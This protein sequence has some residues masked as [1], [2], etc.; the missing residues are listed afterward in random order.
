[1]MASR[2]LLKNAARTALRRNI[3]NNFRISVPTVTKVAQFS[4][5][6]V[7][8]NSV[9]SE[10]NKTLLSELEFEK[11]DSFGLDETFLNY[12]K[13]SRFEI[14]NSDNK[15]LA[16]LVKKTEDEIIH[17]YF[18]VQRVTQASYE[19]KQLEDAEANGEDSEFLRDEFANNSFADVNVVVEKNGKAVGFDL[20]MGVSTN[21]FSVSGI[22]NFDSA[23]LALSDNA[24]DAAKR[25]LKYSG[26][27]FGNLA[28]E[29]Q[30]GIS[31]YL[32]NK[33]IDDQLA[34][35]ILAYSSV[36]ENDEYI[37][38]LEKMSKFFN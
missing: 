13:D 34:E 4:T 2:V 25:D 26:P 38:W 23:R 33:G 10:L 17:V 6:S 24:E 16:E 19:L 18:D 11:K 15:V 8:F 3:V 32:Y 30:E 28:E 35:F 1:M 27:P 9:T 22:A 37:N 29:L 12:L 36:K 7:K 20:V 5:S 31:N 21:Q 14:V